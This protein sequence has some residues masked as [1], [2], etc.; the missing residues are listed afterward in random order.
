MLIV[1]SHSE[2]Y[3]VLYPNILY[4]YNLICSYLYTRYF[5]VSGIVIMNFA[6]FLYIVLSLLYIIF[7]AFTSE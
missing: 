4:I 1:V 5:L 3:D 2:Q 6:V 7:A